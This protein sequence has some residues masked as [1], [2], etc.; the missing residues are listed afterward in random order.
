LLGRLD[1]DPLDLAPQGLPA[2][3][4]LLGGCPAIP[5]VVP[6][7]LHK[8]LPCQFLPYAPCCGSLILSLRD[9]LHES[10]SPLIASFRCNAIVI[11]DLEAPN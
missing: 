5:V 3:A 7:H 11:A 8:E 9:A 4:Q 6:Q 1:I 2:D 10:H